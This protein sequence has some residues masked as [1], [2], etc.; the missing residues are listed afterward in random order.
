MTIIV[1]QRTHTFSPEEIRNW[2]IFSLEEEQPT[3][4][5]N[6]PLVRGAIGDQLGGIVA[7]KNE[8]PEIVVKD[9]ELSIVNL[10]AKACCAEDSVDLIYQAISNGDSSVNLEL[11]DITDGM[12]EL[13]MAY[14][15]SELISEATTPH[16]CCQSR[17]TNIQRFAELIQGTI[18]GPRTP[19]RSTKP[20]V[21]ELKPKDSWKLE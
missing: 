7:D 2:L 14:G 10:S 13:L 21:N 4:K 19:F 6:Y 9:G 16:P 20:L 1:G 8:V 17:V 11:I 5:L 18:I 15:V 12:D 3:W